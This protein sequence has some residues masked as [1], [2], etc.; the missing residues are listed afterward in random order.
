M[1]DKLT[2]ED[3][4]YILWCLKHTRLAYESTE[5]PTYE[6]K[7]AQLDRLSAVEEKLRKIRDQYDLDE[8][9]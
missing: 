2:R 6:L 7:K 8:P 5:Y 3:C 9:R 1:T 4:Q